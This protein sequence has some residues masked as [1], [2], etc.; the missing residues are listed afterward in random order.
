MTQTNQDTDL[1]QIRMSQILEATIGLVAERGG[2]NVRLR[3]ISGATGLSI[4]TLQHYF[5]TR[6][7]LL[8]SAFLKHHE[9]VIASISSAGD[10]SLEPWQRVRK[11]LD[12][13]T[14][15]ASLL[16]RSK[17]WVE[18]ASQASRDEQIRE[19]A[20]HVYE[21]WRNVFDE[22]IREGIKRGQ[23]DPPLPVEHTTSAILAAVDGYEIALTFQ[24]EDAALIKVRIE[25]L[26]SL[27]LGRGV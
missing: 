17:L 23:F 21:R 10:K 16:T 8:K 9:R 6:D 5:T 26:I 18:M 13:L 24:V 15:D 25:P 20:H 19:A 7:N 22:T 4:G 2:D 14:Q 3:E 27:L 1:A 11:M 12:L